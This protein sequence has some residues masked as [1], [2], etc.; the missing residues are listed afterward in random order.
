MSGPSAATATISATPSAR[1]RA[2]SIRRSRRSRFERFTNGRDF[3]L[4]HIDQAIAFKEQ[5][6][7]EV[8]AKTGR[9]LSLTTQLHEMAELR[10]FFFWLS[11]QP[12]Y[13]TRIRYSDAEYFSLSRKDTA[14]ARAGQEIVGPT[15]EQIRLV[16]MAMPTKTAIQRRDRALIAFTFL[17]GMRDNAIASLRLK[18]VDVRERRIEQR[19]AEVRTK[20]SK[21]MT[22]F[23]FPVGDDIRQIVEEWIAFLVE[24]GWGLDDPLFPVTRVRSGSD[25]LFAATGLD[26]R[27][28]TDA[29]PIRRIFKQAFEAAGMRYFNPHSLRSTLARLGQERSRTPEEYK[30]WSQNLGH[31]SVETTMKSYGRVGVHRQQKLMRDMLDHSEAGRSESDGVDVN[32]LLQALEKQQLKSE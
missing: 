20:A 29:S 14:I 5:I 1:A 7:S 24:L 13:R 2:P 19:A 6:A 21:T 31:E 32:R 23:F 15:P 18:H 12:G 27:C 4:F 11:D 28:W 10:A 9:L 8:S 3:E 17:S 30:A 26:R 25:G 16:L 22:T